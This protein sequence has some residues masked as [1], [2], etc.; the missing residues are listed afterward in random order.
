MYHWL[1][2]GVGGFVGAVARY[3]LSGLV[4]RLTSWSSFPFGTMAV[5]VI[6]SLLIGVLMGLVEDRQVL[7]PH[8][9]A[10]LMI[11]MVGSFTTFST[12][13][14]ETYELLTSGRYLAALSN[15]GGS[16]TL[17][18]AAVMAGRTMVALLD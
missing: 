14:L 9:R 3:W 7:A 11:G 18:L 2:V 16:L 15:L 10:L 1:W 6:G 12:L 4:Y 5:N 13:S 17:G 8:A